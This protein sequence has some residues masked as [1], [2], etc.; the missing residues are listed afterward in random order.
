MHG[1]SKMAMMGH[2]PGNE[3][4]RVHFRWPA[5]VWMRSF[6]LRL[7]DKDHKRLNQPT[8][9]HHMEL[10]NFDRRQVL[11]P[12]VERVFGLGEE[13]GSAK[14]PKSIGLPLFAGTDMGLYVM[15]NN[16]TDMDMDGVTLQLTIDYSP[17][18][19]V[20]RPTI[21]LPFKADVNIHPG[22]GDAFD[23]P[24]GGGSQSAV[25]TMEVS[26]RLIAVGGHL[27]DFGKEV[28]LE[29]VASGK[30]LARV[31][32]LR[33]PS[34]E[35]TGV[36]HGLYGILGRG[37]HLIAG[38]RY[39]LVAV[40]QGSPKDSIIGAMGLMGGIFAPDDYAQWP[41]LDR[42]NPDYLIDLSPKGQRGAVAAARPASRAAAKRERTP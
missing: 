42:T 13:T 7:F 2:G 20:P 31:N 37:P 35:V 38:R 9:M 25:F 34:G 16:H 5:D 40:Y 6:D 3:D 1:M 33:T 36:S 18:N 27:H 11:Y 41:K 15:W 22:A 12:M 14:V 4:V 29:D 39:R 30:V 19:L 8:T 10:L 26:G 28:R 32:A 23:L 17:R 21:V 24:P